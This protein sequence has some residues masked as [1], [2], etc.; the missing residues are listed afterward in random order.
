MERTGWLFNFDRENFLNHHP[1]AAWQMLR[2][3][4]YCR[5]HPSWPAGAIRAQQFI[6]A[7]LDRAYSSLL[8]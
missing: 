2:D 1:S 5:S 3:F 4:S 6:H 7:F 8:K